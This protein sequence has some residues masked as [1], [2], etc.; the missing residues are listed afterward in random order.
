MLRVGWVGAID[1]RYA[2]GPG[3]RGAYDSVGT[4]SASSKC[5][6]VGGGRRQSGFDARE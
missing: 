6:E 2:G 3:L 1:V 4:D 5:V